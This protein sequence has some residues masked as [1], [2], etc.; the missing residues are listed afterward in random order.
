[1]SSEIKTAHGAIGLLVVEVEQLRR[2]LAQ[3]KA[4]LGAWHSAFGT[5]QLSHA[6]EAYEKAKAENARL[7]AMLQDSVSREWPSKPHLH[8]LLAPTIELLHG[9]HGYL[10]E[11]DRAIH[12]EL[13]R[14]RS[15]LHSNDNSEKVKS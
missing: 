14:L 8:N 11:D 15:I 4:E 12:N 2:D 9:L 13:S 6:L 1:M 7:A 3:A 5:T 10:S